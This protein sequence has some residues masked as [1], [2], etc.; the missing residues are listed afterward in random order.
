MRKFTFLLAFVLASLFANAQIFRYVKTN[1]TGDGTSWANASSDLQGMVT[2]VG[3]NTTFVLPTVKENLVTNNYKGC[4]YVASG[5][6]TG[7][8]TM[9]EGVGVYGGYAADGTGTRNT[10]LNQTILDGGGTQRVLTQPA[11]P[12]WSLPGRWD[13]FIIQNGLSAAGGGVNI[14]CQGVLANC[15]VRNNISTAQGGGI[16]VTRPSTG[17]GAAILNCV[18]VNNQSSGFGAGI[19]DG[20]GVSFSVIN[21]VIANNNTTTTDGGTGIYIVTGGRFTLILNNIFWGNTKNGVADG[22]EQ[23][24]HQSNPTTYFGL[25]SCYNDYVQ[26]DATQLLFITGSTTV[27]QYQRLPSYYCLPYGKTLVTDQL[28]NPSAC[29]FTNVAPGLVAPTSFSGVTGTDAAKIAELNASNWSLSAGSPCIDKGVT[30]AISYIAYQLATGT[31]A[32]ITG[33]ESGAPWAR[34]MLTDMIGTSRIVG[35][36][37]DLGA[38]EAYDYTVALASNDITKGT[39]SGPGFSRSGVA[40]SVTATATSGNRFVQWSDG[41]NTY[42]TNPLTYTPA[43]NVT[44]TAT[45]SVATSVNETKAVSNLVIVSGRELKFQSVEGSVQVYNTIGKLVV[46]KQNT[47]HSITLNEGGVYLVRIMSDKGI[48][49]QKVLVK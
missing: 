10:G 16:F 2:A 48:Q 6:Y 5:T 12:L 32:I 38:Y 24:M 46:S 28:F 4:V 21:C 7:G 41:T 44:L 22:T 18:I 42:T 30:R 19:Y 45:F 37:P 23:V 35:A 47:S 31:P 27:Y 29:T 33:S 36:T 13:G 8:F 11:T 17:N 1:G 49:T 15:I 43:A 3:A 9:V 14:T 26:V 20:N 34:V 25:L 39:V 40:I